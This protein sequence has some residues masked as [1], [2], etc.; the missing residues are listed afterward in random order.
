M[1]I[2]VLTYQPA[3]IH[4]NDY[5]TNHLLALRD[6]LT[7]VTA[8]GF[9]IRPLCALVDAWRSRRQIS[10]NVVAI[11]CDDSCDFASRELTH[12]AFGKQP[13]VVGILGE[14]AARHPGAQPELHV[15]SFEI[16]SPQARAALDRSCL[17]GRGWW[18]EEAW[19]ESLAS[20]FVHIGNH[21]WDHNHE[22]LPEAVAIARPR[23]SFEAIRDE[24]LAD[25][26]V[27]QAAEYLRA[28]VPNPGCAMFAYPYGNAPDYLAREYLPRHGEA[29]GL[30]AAFTGRAGLWLDATDPWE[31]PRFV[32]T[33]DWSTPDGLAAILDSARTGR[34]W[35]DV[36]ERDLARDPAALRAFAG[37]VREC[38]DPI[39]GWLYPE[40]AILTSYLHAFQRELG[41]AGPVLEIGVYQGKYLS[42][43]YS[44]SAPDEAVVGVD[45]FVGAA[46]P[47]GPMR[48]A[49]KAVENACGDA[50]R[51]HLIVA[52]S[53]ELNAARLAK[54][55]RHDRFR[56]VSV[57]A[58][59][60][61]ELV[62]RDLRTTTPLLQE[63]GIM[64]L[65]D[66]FNCVTPGVMEGTASFFLR[67]QPALAPFAICY[68]KLFV[69]TPA[70]HA[71]YLAA[72]KRFL[73]HA[74]WLGTC[75][76]TRERMRESASYGFTTALFGYEVLAFD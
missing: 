67:D 61:R 10:G 32:C 52:D 33:R 49:R 8:A 73:D 39:P 71:R 76:R 19:H 56:F 26:E 29:L 69:T 47:G 31:I 21:S 46:D 34:N 14:F 11:T 15:T 51:L 54:S 9:R 65:D 60:T 28:R 66:V 1:R 25:L 24:R 35:R 75:A 57:D 70:Y 38:V 18:G 62:L 68:N 58:G 44:L 59:H 41:L 55:A 37:F 40:A 50:S 63:G 20:G 43:L 64:A 45:L 5:A 27:R 13:S 4:G 16:A 7:S 53:M 12:P 6:D 22:A 30:R 48:R 23:G 36:R 74:G 2:P 72:A 42:V 17:A 3:Y